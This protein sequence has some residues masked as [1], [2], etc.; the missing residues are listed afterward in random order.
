M[1]IIKVKLLCQL[2]HILRGGGGRGVQGQIS[3]QHDFKITG[4]SKV[5][6]SGSTFWWGFEAPDSYGYLWG[7]APF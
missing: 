3:W 2:S 5:P 1:D 6:P 4:D 7:R